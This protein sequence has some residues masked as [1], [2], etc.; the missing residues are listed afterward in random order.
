MEGVVLVKRNLYIFLSIVMVSVLA[1]LSLPNGEPVKGHTL[2]VHPSQGLTLHFHNITKMNV[3]RVVPNFNL[4]KFK[5]LAS[6][7]HLGEEVKTMLD[8]K[9]NIECY[10]IWNENGTLEYWIKTGVMKYTSS[11]AYPTV[12]EQPSLPSDEEAINLAISFLKEKGFW[13]DNMVFW[14]ITYDLQR[15]CRKSDGKVLQEFILTKRVHF[16]EI[17]DGGSIIAGAAGK[18]VVT[19]GENNKVVGFIVPQRSLEKVGERE[20]ISYKDAILSLQKG[21]RLLTRPR[22]VLAGRNVTITDVYLLHYAGT[23]PKGNEGGIL[24]PS[25]CLYGRF[26]DNHGEVAFFIDARK[27]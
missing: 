7:F 14:G 15:L 17:I 9:G 3:Y 1:A 5:S 20:I 10:S 23:I 25:Y 16:K 19:I 12:D 18:I 2:N 22:T 4:S 6:E 27:T 21:D 8:A 11:D 13:K 26:D 24:I